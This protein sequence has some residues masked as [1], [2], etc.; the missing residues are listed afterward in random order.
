M[1]EAEPCSLSDRPRCAPRAAYCLQQ[2]L[3]GQS[4]QL[5]PYLLTEWLEKAAIAQ[6]RVPEMLLPA[7]LDK[8]RQQRDLRPAILS[9]LGQRGAWLAAQNPDW[10]Y[11]VALITEADWETS[12]SNAR[13]MFLQDLRCHNPDR[14]RDLLQTTWSQESAG[15]RTK[16]LATFR[17]GLS[18]ADEPFLQTALSDRRSK[19]VRRAAADLLACLP[20]S[21]LC[22]QMAASIQAFVTRSP[23]S[24]ASFKVQLPDILALEL[25]QL[26]IEPKPA[27]Q[28]FLNLG[29]KAGWLLQ[30][31]GATPLSFW[32]ETWEMTAAEI[33][34][35]AQQHEWQLVLLQGWT[36]AA[37]RQGDRPWIMALLK[38]VIDGSQWEGNVL[39][40]P[41]IETLLNLLSLEQQNAVLLE[42]LRSRQDSIRQPLTIYLLCHSSG[43]WSSELAQEVLTRLQDY[44]AHNT[45]ISKI[46]WGLRSDLKEFACF[47]PV[48]FLP[49]VFQ[50]QAQLPPDSIWLQ[51]VGELLSLLQFRQ[52]MAQAFVAGDG[53]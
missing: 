35:L 5:Y 12:P 4:P 45:D 25:I 40:Q 17:T 8:G 24:P 13:L 14:A 42:L 23:G 28:P 21:H 18:L 37:Q 19:E 31:I 6:Q 43:Q 44:L 47:M 52:E 20:D 3:Q 16:F 30:M 10:S 7:L 29:E 36:V 15:D 32:N 51:S 41:Q 33:I 49:E 22:Q 11:A 38:S 26:G 1:S 50:L 9:V 27:H 2:I 46:T 53:G 48:S 34:S 39:H